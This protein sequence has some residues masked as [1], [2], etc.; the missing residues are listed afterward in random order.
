[1]YKPK[2]L[3]IGSGGSSGIVMLGYLY[4]LYEDNYFTEIKKY[5]GCSVGSIIILLIALGYTPYE[6]AQTSSLID[7]FVDLKIN[8]KILSENFGLIKPEKYLDI[9]E[10][11]IL[12]KCDEIPTLNQL[13]K[14]YKIE[15]TMITLNISTGRT[16]YLHYEKYPNLSV[17]KAIEMSCAIPF[18]F[19]K[20]LYNGFYYVD[21]VFGDPFPSELFDNEETFCI[22]IDTILNP[23]KDFT[24]YFKNFTLSVI[25]ASKERSM[26][27][28]KKN[29]KIVTLSIDDQ[30][31]IPKI[32]SDLFS[33]GMREGK[34]F[35]STLKK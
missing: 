26:K 9:I 10:K 22:G 12:K 1:M 2:N 11:L 27:K 23:I 35:L 32:N 14:K 31:I 17:L 13:Y 18:I 16:S 25:N 19:S 20:C 6:I 5:Y 15:I 4:P 28:I 30:N 24:S 8:W 34:I 33:E 21:G 7:F 3:F 29:V